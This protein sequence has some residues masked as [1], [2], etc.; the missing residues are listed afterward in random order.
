MG[1]KLD[2]YKEPLMLRSRVFNDKNILRMML[3]KS[4]FLTLI[5]MT[6]KDVAL[7]YWYT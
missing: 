4:I 5:L 6:Q 7:Y 1:C 2:M 3:D